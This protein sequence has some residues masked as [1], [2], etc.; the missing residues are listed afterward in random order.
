LQ[1]LDGAV[2]DV[3]ATDVQQRL[4]PAYLLQIADCRL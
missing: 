3:Q 1:R 2:I 4:H